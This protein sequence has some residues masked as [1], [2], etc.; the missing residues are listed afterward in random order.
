M[1]TVVIPIIKCG[2]HQILS[3]S[4]DSDLVAVSDPLGEASKVSY[5]PWEIGSVFRKYRLANAGGYETRVGNI[6]DA[7]RFLGVPSLF[8]KTTVQADEAYGLSI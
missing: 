8:R 1:Y 7:G 5:L 2:P 6:I 3:S 4:R